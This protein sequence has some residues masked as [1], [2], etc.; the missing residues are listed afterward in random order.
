MRDD[1]DREILEE[2]LDNPMFWGSKW[3]DLEEF[4][5]EEMDNG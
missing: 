2:L 1:I 4:L 5:N 3:T